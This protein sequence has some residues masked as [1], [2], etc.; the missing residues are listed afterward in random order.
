MTIKEDHGKY[1][2][3]N[4][5]FLAG[6]YKPAPTEMFMKLSAG[7][8]AP[9]PIN[10]DLRKLVGPLEVYNQ[11][12]LG[13][14]TANAIAA[15]YK[16]MSIIKHRRN[17]SL[18]RLFIYYNERVMID[19]V[20]EDSG[21]Y[22][23][24][25]FISMQKQGACV[26]TMWPYV[27][28]RLTTRPTYPCY[29]EA[30][31]HRTN[32]YNSQLDPFNMVYSIKHCL[33]LKLPVV[34]GVMV[35]ESF[36][37]DRAAKTGLIPLPNTQTERLLGG[38]ALT[39]VGYDDDKQHFIVLNSWGTV[40]GDKGMCYIPYA[41]VANNDLCNDCHAFMSVEL[42]LLGDDDEPPEDIFN[43][44]SPGNIFGNCKTC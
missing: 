18:S 21:A 22:I 5:K 36:Q 4:R 17:V 38:H 44:V 9:L 12:G 11:G 37:A 41:F 32:G 19:K 15:A 31:N 42:K 39:C 26:E 27:E 34:I 25:G 29:L 8:L 28:S 2:N 16:I 23:K 10:C 20:N 24:D 13:S 30:R 14:C 33:A 35:Y 6:I 40:W 3:I 1:G 43:C 7:P